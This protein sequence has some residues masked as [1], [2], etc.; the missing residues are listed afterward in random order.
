MGSPLEKGF[1]FGQRGNFAG[2]FDHAIHDQGGGD[3]H[4]EIGEAHDIGD[5]FDF[6]RQAEF[7]G[8][9][10]GDFCEGLALGA[11][12]SEDLEFFHFLVSWLWVFVVC[13]SL[14]LV[15][16]LGGWAR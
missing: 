14:R 16:C 1:G 15:F 9:L 10:L 6:I 5:F 12:G 7:F 3:H 13:K 4:S 2:G 8:G 11:A